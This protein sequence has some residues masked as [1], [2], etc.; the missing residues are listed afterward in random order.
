MASLASQVGMKE[1]DERLQ[2]LKDL[3]AAWLQGKKPTLVFIDDV[4]GI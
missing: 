2:L 4:Q 1:F 3:E